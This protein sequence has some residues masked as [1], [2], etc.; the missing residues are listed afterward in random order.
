MCEIKNECRETMKKARELQERLGVPVGERCSLPPNFHLCHDERR[1]ETL[2]EQFEAIAEDCRERLALAELVFELEAIRAEAKK[3]EAQAAADKAKAIVAKPAPIDPR[4]HGREALEAE[5]KPLRQ[6]F[7]DLLNEG[8]SLARRLGKNQRFIP[9]GFNSFSKEKLEELVADT[10]AGVERLRTAQNKLA[11]E[12]QQKL[13]DGYHAARRSGRAN[14]PFALWV[15][16]QERR[17]A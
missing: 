8:N 13:L 3:A 7:L 1:I 11:H 14:K 9:Q 12:R 6:R 2:T 4:R 5:R 10:K 17:A 15:K 16:D